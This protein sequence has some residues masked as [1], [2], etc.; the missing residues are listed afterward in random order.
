MW[1]VILIISVVAET[2]LFVNNIGWQIKNAVWKEHR[3]ITDKAGKNS[4]TLS[5]Y[6]YMKNQLSSS[7][8]EISFSLSQIYVNIFIVICVD[9]QQLFALRRVWR[10]KGLIYKYQLLW[11]LHLWTNN[12]IFIMLS[13]IS[14]ST[15]TFSAVFAPYKNYS[16][17][18][19]IN[20]LPLL[21]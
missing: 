13:T 2:C 20:F 19:T 18:G 4:I 12:V 9:K 5:D 17:T 10:K 7:P 21:R 6:Y 3:T 8:V 14:W 15:T 11:Q 1:S 16:L